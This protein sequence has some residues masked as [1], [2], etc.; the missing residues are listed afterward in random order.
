MS[1]VSLT[2]SPLIQGNHDWDNWYYGMVPNGVFVLS[3]AMLLYLDILGWSDPLSGLVVSA[4]SPPV[5][6]AAFPGGGRMTSPKKRGDDVNEKSPLKAG[7]HDEF[8]K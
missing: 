3:T 1:M 6:P 7:L 5:T 8:S 4:T 2:L